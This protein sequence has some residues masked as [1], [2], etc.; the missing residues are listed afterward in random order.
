MSKFKAG[1]NVVC[2]ENRVYATL[3][4]Q[5]TVIR[6]GSN[7]AVFFTD[8][9]GDENW[10]G[11][12]TFELVVK[13]SIDFTKPVETVTGLPVEVVFT[14][15]RDKE[16]PVAAYIG[17]RL[18]PDRFTA[19]G[20]YYSNS[21]SDNDLRNV[22]PKPLEAEIYVNVYKNNDGGLRMADNH[23]TRKI[24]DNRASLNRVGCIKIKIKLV[25][26]QYDA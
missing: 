6:V 25:E 14:D 20:K 2:V 19:E 8:D 17:D 26:G 13:P 16:Y 1:D 12:D 10:Y 9:Q 5:Y 23:P 22:A 7:G 21:T 15:G 3:N 24:A 4:K 11:P 18:N